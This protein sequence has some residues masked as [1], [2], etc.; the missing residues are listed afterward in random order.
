MILSYENHALFYEYLCY[1]TSITFAV[2]RDD[3]G[4]FYN[5]K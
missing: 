5:E 3:Y 4:N 1:N 2:R